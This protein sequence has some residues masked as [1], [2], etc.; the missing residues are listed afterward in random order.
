MIIEAFTTFSLI[1]WNM[2]CYFM[3]ICVIKEM[4]GK[5]TVWHI[6][7]NVLFGFCCMA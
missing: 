2:A 5:Y 3:L 7:D 6:Q 1:S 4:Y